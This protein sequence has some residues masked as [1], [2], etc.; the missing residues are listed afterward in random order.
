MMK[1]KLAAALGLHAALSMM[2]THALWDWIRQR[3]GLAD[4]TERLGLAKL[5]QM[6]CK[7]R[8]AAAVRFFRDAFAEK[9]KLAD[10]LNA[11]HRYN[12]ACAAALAGCGQGQ[13]S[14]KLDPKE[15]AL[16]RAQAL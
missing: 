3:L 16:V 8:Y 12:A 11:G 7:K 2:L 14:D 15:R 1:A 6:R 9:P 10:D 13:D 4:T 5:C